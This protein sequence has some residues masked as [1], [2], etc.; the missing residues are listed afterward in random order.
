MLKSTPSGSIRTPLRHIEHLAIDFQ[1]DNAS[2]FSVS[3][4]TYF[5][6]GIFIEEKL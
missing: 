1:P 4:S 3:K 6:W 2:T 5:N